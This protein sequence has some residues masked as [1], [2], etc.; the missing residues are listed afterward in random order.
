VYGS[1]K[2]IRKG[3]QLEKVPLIINQ[4]AGALKNPVGKSYHLPSAL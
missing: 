3:K 4:K 1:E 2:Q